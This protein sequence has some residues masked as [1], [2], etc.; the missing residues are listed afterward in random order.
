MGERERKRW[1]RGEWVVQGEGRSKR[2]GG[3]SSRGE[4]DLSWPLSTPGHPDHPRPPR[5]PQVTPGHPSHPRPL[6]YSNTIGKCWYHSAGCHTIQP[7]NPYLFVSSSS[8]P[9]LLAVAVASCCRRCSPLLLLLP[10]VIAIA[11]HCRRCS[12]LSPK[13][14]LTWNRSVQIKTQTK[15]LIQCLSQNHVNSMSK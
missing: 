2:G 11:L 15:E 8:T 3:R 14:K 12:P 4:K 9:L 7:G 13:P 10:V 1:G 5:P 6:V